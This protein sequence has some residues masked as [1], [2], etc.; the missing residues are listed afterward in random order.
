MPFLLRFCLQLFVI[1]LR[2]K[3]NLDMRE[4]PHNFSEMMQDPNLLGGDICRD[5]LRNV[6]KTEHNLLQCTVVQFLI[7][8]LIHV[9][10][11]F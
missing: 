8:F 7:D 4:E 1:I 10:N 2:F 11:Y 6:L 5:F 9:R 3:V